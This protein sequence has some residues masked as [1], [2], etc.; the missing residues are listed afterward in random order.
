LRSNNGG[1][2]EG[3]DRAKSNR[4]GDEMSLIEQSQANDLRREFFGEDG[5]DGEKRSEE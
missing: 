2:K 3:S 4:D 1:G 5:R